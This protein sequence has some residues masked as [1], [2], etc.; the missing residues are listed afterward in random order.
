MFSI[1]TLTWLTVQADA[2]PVFSVNPRKDEAVVELKPEDVAN[3][4]PLPVDKPV[5]GST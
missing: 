3:T 4:P 1:F 2:A 5:V